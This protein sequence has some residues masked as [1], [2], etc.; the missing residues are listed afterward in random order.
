M[1]RKI[2]VVITA[3]PSYSRIRTALTAIS[4]HPALELQMV[5]AA[6][7]LL[8]KFGSTIDY[9]Q[10]DG[11]KIDAEVQSVV[12]GE[13][14]LASAKTVGLGTLELSSVFERL[15]PDVVV[16]IADRFETIST[17]ICA[18]LM[19]IPL[20][21][22]QGGEIS[23]NIDDKIRHAITKLADIHL[24]SNDEARQRVIQLGECSEK[25]YNTGCPSIDIAASICDE[26]LL[27][28]EPAS[29]Y[30]G[31]GRKLKPDGEYL[32]V[33][34]HPVT[35]EYP[36]SQQQIEVTLNVVKRLGIPAFWFWPNADAGSDGAA[37]AIR[38]FRETNDK[39]PT[40]FL[41]NLEGADFLKLLRKS[42]C[43]IGNSSA[44]IRECAYL[45][46]PA[47]NIGSRQNGRKRADN[48]ID[49]GYKADAIFEA[50]KTQL[51]H[52]HY[53]SSDIYGTGNSGKKV[54][55]ILA[56]ADLKYTKRL[57]F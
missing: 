1:R 54:A 6:S 2:C 13:N 12:D 56:H 32:V 44:G 4:E 41:R 17:A 21:H 18:A 14:L 55:E 43:L 5:V 20:A 16:T 3:R 33:L 37:K 7:A 30:A 35:T 10:Q 42:A 40:H 23:G 31:V 25:V 11:F 52:G 51:K 24:V 19:N 22:I 45:G 28:F 29:I 47:V 38:S 34:Q 27:G 49:V 39:L 36:E 15:K 46:V 8:K 48:V 9:I 50:V 53:V 57:T 26:S